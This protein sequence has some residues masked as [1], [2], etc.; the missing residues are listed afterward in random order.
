M[1]EIQFI[2]FIRVLTSAEISSVKNPVSRMHYV[3]CT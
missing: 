1:T 3:S 2:L